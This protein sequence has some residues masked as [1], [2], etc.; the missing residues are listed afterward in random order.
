MGWKRDVAA[1]LYRRNLLPGL[2]IKVYV[3]PLLVR[4]K[5]NPY[6]GARFF[7]S[8]YK[9]C[10]TQGLFSDSIT[11]AP[12]NVKPAHC[13]YHYNATENSIISCLV[14]HPIRDAP[15]VLDIGSGAGHWIDFWL[16]TFNASFV[17]GVDVSRTC[18]EALRSKYAQMENVVI[19]EGDISQRGEFLGR[20]FDVICAIGV[21][22]HIV[23]DAL[24]R[25]ALANMGDL[26]SDGGVIIV[27]GHFGWVTQDI[28]FHVTDDFE[29]MEQAMDSLLG[30]KYSLGGVKSAKE[31]YVNKRVRSLRLWKTA[32][33]EAGLRVHMLQKTPRHFGIPTPENNIMVLKRGPR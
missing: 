30:V 4:G 7:E 33:A 26:L 3:L 31:I 9:S 11:L 2:F 6:Q 12:F 8:Y 28:Q 23:D 20:K 19:M 5:R 22:F 16:A 21:V 27:G 13:K 25:Q 18:T 24:W 14:R 32:A 29:S 1:W 15:A 17:C 10:A